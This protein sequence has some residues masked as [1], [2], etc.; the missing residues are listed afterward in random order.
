MVESIIVQSLIGLT[1]IFFQN[2]LINE[3]MRADA[4]NTILTM[5]KT[6]PKEKAIQTYP[7]K[8]GPIVCP[9]SIIVLSVPIAA[10]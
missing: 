7:L 5:E 1:F 9:I 4:S 8:I 3:K 2:P 6:P 10:P